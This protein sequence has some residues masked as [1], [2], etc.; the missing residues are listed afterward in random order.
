[1]CYVD[2]LNQIIAIFMA[3][4]HDNMILIQMFLENVYNM[5]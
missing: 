4:F 1:M 5:E 3:L 2:Y